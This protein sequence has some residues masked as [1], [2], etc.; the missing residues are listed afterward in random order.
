MPVL[1]QYSPQVLADF[2]LT[3]G[4]MIAI[5]SLRNDSPS[6]ALAAV[7]RDEQ[8]AV[9]ARI[10]ETALSELPAITGWRATFR[11]FGVDPTQYRSAPE[12]LLRRLTKKGDIPFI[13]P[14]VD[15]GNLVSIRYALP[16][17]I[18]DTRRVQGG[19][20]VRYADGD[21]PFS[22]HGQ[23]QSANPDPGEVVFTDEDRRVVARRWCWHQSLE[24]TTQSDTTD[25]LV[26]IEAQHA[27]G[28]TDV[29]NAVADF[30]ALARTYVGGVA[31]HAILDTTNPAFVV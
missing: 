6:E 17:A 25:V 7:Y 1:F 21:E 13:N 15:I 2:P 9:I 16:V 18:V 27:G 28:R 29:E 14:L 12:A 19:I 3:V 30:L 31:Q 22:D 11:K 10:G 5:N 20:T 4:G 26:T 8:N 24:S 23:S